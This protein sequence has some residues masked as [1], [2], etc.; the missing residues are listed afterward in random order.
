M[1][2]ILSVGPAMASCGF[3]DLGFVNIV[4]VGRNFV[5]EIHC[6]KM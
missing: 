4:T 1:Y 2:V 5:V 3:V 6:Q